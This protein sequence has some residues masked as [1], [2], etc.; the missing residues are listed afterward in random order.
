[1]VNSQSNNF[2]SIQEV[3]KDSAG[4]ITGSTITVICVSD[5]DVKTLE[6]HDEGMYIFLRRRDVICQVK[7][8]MFIV[9]Q[10]GY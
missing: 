7:G 9:W 3:E 5:S 1:M 8:N 4:V 2:I 10:N 6:I